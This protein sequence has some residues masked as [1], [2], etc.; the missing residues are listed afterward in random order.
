LSSRELAFA[1]IAANATAIALRNARVMQSLRDQTQKVNF[2]RFEAERRLRAL[3]RY[4]NLFTS[5]ADGLA[6]VDAD[7]RMLFANPRAYEIAGVEE[8]D[9]RGESM[10]K[11]IDPDDRRLLIDIWRRVREGDFPRGIDLRMRRPD[12]EKRIVS[13]SF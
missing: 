9:G 13:C 1:R 6:A 3:K 7:G 2:A 10:R 8:I 11:L 4:A 12:G 5:A